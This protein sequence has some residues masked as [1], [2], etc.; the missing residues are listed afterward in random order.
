[1]NQSTVHIDTNFLNGKKLLVIDDIP[2]NRLLPGMILRPFGVNVL[3]FASVKEAIT[4]CSDLRF[5]IVLLDLSMP[6]MDGHSAVKL[7]KS[8]AKFVGAKIYAYTAYADVTEHQA[9]KVIGFDGVLA[10]PIKN[11]NLFDLFKV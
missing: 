5:D 6:L 7:F 2:F 11:Q 1:M 9:L 8:S 10:K 3:E 4:E